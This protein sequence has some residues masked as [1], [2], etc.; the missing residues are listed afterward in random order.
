MRR[1]VGAY[2]PFALPHWRCIEFVQI[3]LIDATLGRGFMHDA[4]PLSNFHVEESV[5][6]GPD[7]CIV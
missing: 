5:P 1:T 2:N 6:A 7:R 4:A 3:T